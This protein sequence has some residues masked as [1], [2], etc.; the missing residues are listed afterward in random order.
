ME[1]V[2]EVNEDLLNEVVRQVTEAVSPRR[3]ILFGSAATLDRGKPADLDLLIVMADGTHRRDTAMA[4]HRKLAGLRIAKDIV[5]VTENDLLE[6]GENP[7]LV[8][9]PALREGREL[10]R[11]S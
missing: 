9:F 1:A 5:V 8:L 6:Y 3:I 11:A 4:L 2:Q 7:S 10:F